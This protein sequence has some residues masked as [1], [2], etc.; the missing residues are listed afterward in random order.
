[1]LIP[2]TTVIGTG[3]GLVFGPMFRTILTGVGRQESGSPSGLLPAVQ[4][5]GGSL[6]VAAIG[7]FY[8]TLSGDRPG[9][10]RAMTLTAVL[11]AVTFVLV[12]L[13]PKDKPMD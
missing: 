3:M 10:G 5:F 8:F 7:T 13:F 2:P 11:I 1:M 12:F 9:T 4:Q 6:G